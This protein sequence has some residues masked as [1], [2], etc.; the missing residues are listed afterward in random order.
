[1]DSAEKAIDIDLER[2]QRAYDRARER[3]DKDRD[4]EDI[5]FLRAEL[6]LKRAISRI[7]VA[8]KAQ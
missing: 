7:K 8:N 2:A 4:S 1:V 3:L 5:D 6:A